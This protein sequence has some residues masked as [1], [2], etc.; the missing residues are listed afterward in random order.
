MVRA[1]QTSLQELLEGSKQYQVPL[2]QRT[3]SWQRAHLER[4]WEDVAK[5][6][7]DRVQ[8]PGY[9][10]C[11]WQQ[12]AAARMWPDCGGRS[13]VRERLGALTAGTC[14]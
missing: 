7:A 1:V 8:E 14:G 2:Y 12:A 6:A 3:H 10:A 13:R 5:L 11:Q 4:L 9:Y